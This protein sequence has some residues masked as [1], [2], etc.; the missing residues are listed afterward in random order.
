MDAVQLLRAV[1][2][3]YMLCSQPEFTALSRLDKELKEKNLVKASLLD[4]KA[5]LGRGA[6]NRP[7]SSYPSPRMGEG[8]VR[9][10][11][12]LEDF[13]KRLNL[14][15]DSLDSGPEKRLPSVWATHFISLVQGLGFMRPSGHA[16]TSAEYQALEAWKELLEGFSSLDDVLGRITRE[17][18]VRKIRDMA[19]STL[20]QK[21]AGERPVEVQGIL[22]SSGMFFDKVWLMGCDEDSLPPS[23]R[24][25]RSY[26]CPFCRGT[27]SGFQLM[28]GFPRSQRRRSGDTQVRAFPLIRVKG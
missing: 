28:S 7:P 6:S 22:E 18:S 9:A 26:R 27:V 19:S 11:A 15:I 1:L 16:L 21:E 5:M 2:S 4:L 13:G 23:H 17:D 10:N 24:Q 3:P 20:H 25:T 12:G 14:W 8:R